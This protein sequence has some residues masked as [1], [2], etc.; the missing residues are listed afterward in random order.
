MR[1]KKYANPEVVEETPV[2]E[3][4]EVV[5]ETPVE[6]I[7][8]V[9]EETPVEEIEEVVEET[10][11]EEKLVKV[12]ANKLNIRKENSKDSDVVTVVEKGQ[13]LKLLELEPVDGFY[14]VD[15]LTGSE[16]YCMVE[17]VEIV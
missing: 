5:E 3:I 6:E 12:L 14:H 17:F 7:E 10:P 16:G 4:E 1:N 8:E 13:V 11:V 15:T 2:E 9:V